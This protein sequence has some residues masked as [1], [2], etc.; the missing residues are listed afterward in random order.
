MSTVKVK[1]TVCDQEFEKPKNEYN[2]RKKL[3]RPLYCGLSCAGK[4]NLKNIPEDKRLHPENLISDNRLD[5]L[6]PFRYYMKCLRNG[7][8]SGR[9][10]KPYTITLE[11]M[12]KQWDKQEGICPYTGWNL[13]LPKSTMDQIPHVPERASL[14]RIDSSKIY[15]RGNIQW[16]ATIAN[17]AK[18]AWPEDELF[19]FCEA[20]AQ[21]R[22][23][24]SY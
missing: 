11:D 14:D 16:V 23:G 15:E 5:E 19:R 6:S 2:R 20:V 17:Y 13:I 24:F 1:C 4:A 10:R 8:S 7:P 12:K 18:H 21:N 3:G 22:G 9:N